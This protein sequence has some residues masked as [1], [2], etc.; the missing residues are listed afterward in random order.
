MNLDN[1]TIYNN[2][3]KEIQTLK[4]E[5]DILRKELEFYKS[6]FKTHRNSVVF[7]LTIKKIKGKNVW[8]DH[9]LDN[10]SFIESLDKDD[11]VEEWLKPI[12]CE[13]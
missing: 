1:G 11:E 13:R 2:L 12:K 7:N 10:R 8:T 3:E 5:K 6:L 4:Y 9:I